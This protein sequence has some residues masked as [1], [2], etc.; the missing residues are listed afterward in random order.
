MKYLGIDYGS[1]RIGIALSDDSGTL[2]FPH[3]VIE[4][5]PNVVQQ[6]VALCQ[7]EAIDTIIIGESHDLSGKPN[8]IMKNLLAF[9]D[10]LRTQA[11][12]PIVFEPE[13]FT[14]AEAERV[15]GKHPLLDASAAAIILNSFLQKQHGNH[16]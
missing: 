12:L 11:N 16:R 3:S 5:N 2:A 14:S 7:K 10:R 1:K 15:Q 4:N 8:R 13:M 9:A 6:I